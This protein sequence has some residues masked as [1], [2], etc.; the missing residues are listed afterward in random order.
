MLPAKLRKFKIR[1]LSLLKNLKTRI[2]SL[3]KNPRHDVALAITV[4]FIIISAL[5]FQNSWLRTGEGFRDIYTSLAHALA[6]KESTV[7]KLSAVDLQDLGILPKDLPLF[8]AKLKLYGCS[9]LDKT[10][11]LYFAVELGSSAKIL[12]FTV[13]LAIFPLLLLLLITWIMLRLPNNDFNKDTKPLK[14]VKTIANFTWRPLKSQICG[15]ALFLKE[16]KAYPIIWAA[17]WG[18]NFNFLTIIL[19][20]IAYYYYFVAGFDFVNLYMQFYKLLLDLSTLILFFPGWAWAVILILGFGLFRKFASLKKLK[21]NEKKCEE[22]A[23]ELP[24]AVFITG[25]MG[26]GKTTFNTELAITYNKYFRDVADKKMFEMSMRFPNFPWINAENCVK[27]GLEHH[28]IYNLATC[29]QF[30]KFLRKCYEAPQDNP[31]NLDNPE[32]RKRLLKIRELRKR[33]LKSRY[34]YDFDNFL[35]DY[36]TCKYAFTYYDNL[37]SKNIFDILGD[38]VRL[39]F[40]YVISCSLMISNYSIRVD[41]F[42]KDKGNFPL[43]DIDFFRNDPELIDKN[44]RRSHIIDFDAL[45]LGLKFVENGRFK[46]SIDFGVI[47]VTEIGKERANQKTI[48]GEYFSY[49]RTDKD[50]NKVTVTPDS[51]LMNLDIKECRH[52]ATVDNFPFVVW[53]LDD[54]RAASLNADNKELCDLLYIVKA[55]DYKFITPYFALDELIYNAAS[56]LMQKFHDKDRFYKGNNTLF[57]HTLRNFFSRFVFKPYEKNFN[58]YSVSTLEFNVQDGKE[59]DDGH[60]LKYRMS[61]KKIHSARFATDC[62]GDYY[63]EKT[64]R[65]HAG[66][67]D[68]SEYKGKQATREEM[69]STHGYFPRGMDMMFPKETD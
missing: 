35:F 45:R 61:K 22:V 63:Y 67:V 14:L 57:R 40:I 46:D 38:Y 41:D 68:I 53:L 32:Q 15:Y 37:E 31:D 10:T 50:G 16:H 28:T 27:F 62:Y 58:M 39:Y 42:K 12:A 48:K 24:V 4:A 49:E 5:C 21:K 17:I 29:L 65:S 54:N 6:D 60:K 34:G 47:V 33:I 43:W 56:K 30:I 2:I 26:T 9:L 44:S 23:A 64:K 8:L 52:R 25:T 20:V 1:V 59:S 19:E 13:L 51:D 18:F 55:S 3:L 66:I 11:Y 36:D 69:N 7:N